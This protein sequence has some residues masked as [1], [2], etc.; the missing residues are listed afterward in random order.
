MSRACSYIL[1][2]LLK[3]RQ[4]RESFGILSALLDYLVVVFN[5]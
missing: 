4:G 5:T 1:I 3:L 2:C